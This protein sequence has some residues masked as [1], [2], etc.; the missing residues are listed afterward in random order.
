MPIRVLSEQTI[1]KI[2]AGE[3]IER[4]A[5]IVKE[6]LEN[7]LD[8]GADQISIEIAEGGITEIRVV[9]NGC[10]IT[11]DDLPLAVERHATS[12]LSEFSDLKR[13]NTLGFRGEALAS[14]AA[15]ASLEIR[16]AAGL[17]GAAVLRTEFGALPAIESTAAVRGTSV[18]VR[19]LFANVPAR[20]KFLRQAATETTAIQRLVAAYAASRPESIFRLDV[21][22]RS[23][24]ATGGSGDLVNAATA[25]FGSDVGSVA[26]VLPDLDSTAAVPGVSASGWVTGPQLT[27]SHRQQMHFFVN[28][29]LIQHRTLGFV[30]EECF[31]TLLMVGRHPVVLIR[32]EIEPDLVDANVHPTKAEVRFVD[33]RT[34][35][36][37]VQRAVHA[38]L[39]QAPVDELPRVSFAI[40]SAPVPAAMQPTLMHSPARGPETTESPV[41]DSR[42]A[43]RSLPML[44]V[45]G[46]VGASYIIAEGPEGLYLIDQHAAH[47]RVMYERIRA[48]LA[49]RT[50][51]I[52]RL[53]DPMVID[54]DTHE[55]AVM[56]RSLPELNQIGFEIEAFGDQSF[57]LRALPAMMTGVDIQERIHL[58]LRELADGGVGE[59]WLDSVAI[60]TACH[61]SIRAGQALSIAEMR[62]LVNQLEQT[63]HPRACGHGRP[64]M[65][66]MSQGDLA[67][68]FARR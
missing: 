31:H 60:S 16:S 37:A 33:E 14:I 12:K 61:T 43:D 40:P 19:D 2:A 32:I 36:R 21:D 20:R 67:R 23:L 7:A 24:F 51:D 56:E 58:I 46:Q 27:R 44:R 38:A 42:P 62:E 39:A 29:R 49:D 6:L 50:G 54:V 9:D 64:T 66:L 3:V 41:A 18:I 57:V 52:Q 47:E 11:V 5:S 26:L 13:V 28:G 65:L 53:L 59:S 15:V 63:E 22:G 10:G 48:Q 68:Q 25:V 8:S 35:C 1:G 34:V 17:D 45:L 4:P 55:A 30:V